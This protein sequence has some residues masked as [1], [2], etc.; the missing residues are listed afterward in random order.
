MKPLLQSIVNARAHNT[1]KLRHICIGNSSADMDSVVGSMLMSHLKSND[2]FK[3]SP[4]IF[5]PKNELPYRIEIMQ[6]LSRFGMT[7][8]WLH[9]NVFFKED[10]MSDTLDAVESVSLVDFNE[11]PKELHSILS[12]RVHHIIDHHVDNGLYTSSLKSKKIQL[13][14]SAVTL[15]IEEMKHA[16][17]TFD[18]E[19][20]MF[21]SAPLLL[22]SYNFNQN[23][24][25]S[26]WTQEDAD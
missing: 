2:S 26:K 15:V 9:E 20:A 7:Q 18:S 16:N 14:G 13:I 10:L 17:I 8:E 21:A 12:P 1:P 25:G 3:Y 19:I 11:L 4:V 6:H 5:C 22:D 23:L 24:E